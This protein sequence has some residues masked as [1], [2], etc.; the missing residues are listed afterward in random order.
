MFVYSYDNFS[1]EVE[2]PFLDLLVN[3]TFS[4][5]QCGKAAPMKSLKSISDGQFELKDSFVNKLFP[6]VLCQVCCKS[7]IEI[8]KITKIVKMLD[9]MV[10]NFLNSLNYTCQLL[11]SDYNWK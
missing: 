4:C 5:I 2:C 6:K 3:T 1:K 8:V 9:F 11:F 7:V 10:K